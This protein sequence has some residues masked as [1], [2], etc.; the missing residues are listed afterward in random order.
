MVIGA[1]LKQIDHL[2]SM[3]LLLKSK[4]T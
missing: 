2:R 3:Y 4:S 1:V